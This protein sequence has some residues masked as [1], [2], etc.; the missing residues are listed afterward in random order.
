ML[1]A[2]AYVDRIDFLKYLPL[3]DC[4]A[5]GVETCGEFLEC[6]KREEKSPG[7]CPRIP[8][9]LYPGFDLALEADKMLPKFSCVTDPRPGPIGVVEINC[10]DVDS[11]IL[12]SGNHVHTQNVITAVLGTTRSPF[13]LLFSD[14]K[15]STV[16]M[17]VI[18]ETLTAEQIR[19]ALE[20]SG[21]S[22]EVFGHPIIMPGLAEAVSA[23][24]HEAT[25]WHVI[26]GP[27]CAAELP[28]F[29]AD[30]WLPAIQSPSKPEKRKGKKR[31]NSFFALQITT[32]FT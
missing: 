15:G 14:T 27:V 28:L 23:Q 32:R 25:G 29:L 30:R 2:D 7:D 3:T 17:A 24:L 9:S 26:T 1:L 16:D 18:Y 11:P 5:C 19:E 20:T 12:V 22:G 4:A 8:E 6:L 13:Y 21:I 31:D 10:P